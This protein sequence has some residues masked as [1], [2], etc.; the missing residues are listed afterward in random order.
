MPSPIRDA[1]IAGLSYRQWRRFVSELW[2]HHRTGSGNPDGDFSPHEEAV[3]RVLGRLH[4]SGVF[5]RLGV[6]LEVARRVDAEVWLA[7]PDVQLLEIEWGEG[8][9]VSVPVAA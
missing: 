7:G 9:K 1:E 4:A 8:V 6:P 3:V 5:G 2:P